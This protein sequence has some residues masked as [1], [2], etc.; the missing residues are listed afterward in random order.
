MGEIGCS[1]LV[2]AGMRFQGILPFS[3]KQL[4][5]GCPLTLESAALRKYLQHISALL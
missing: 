3:A 5:Q 2:G 1:V 4:T